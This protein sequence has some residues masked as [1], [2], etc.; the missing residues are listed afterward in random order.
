MK[1]RKIFV[2]FLA[3]CLCLSVAVHAE[4][5]A[6]DSGDNG[7]SSYSDSEPDPEPAPDPEPE[8]DPE[9]VPDPEPEPDPEPAPNPEPDPDPEPVPDPEPE[10]DP[11][12]APD[13]EPEPDPD[14]TPVP[15][16]SDGV[17]DPVPVVSSDLST[18]L[19]G[20]APD[21]LYPA[22]E[23]AMSPYSTYSIDD[24]PASYASGTMADAIINLFGEYQPR[25]QTVTDYHSDGTSVSYEQYVP[26]AAGMDWNW[27]AGAALFTVVLW[28]LFKLLGVFFKNV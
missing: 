25:T 2:L 20:S 21:S 16:P 7:G 4:D 23:S 6:P 10:P 1:L 5:P 8:P 9:P 12:P 14:P 28:S 11:E 15:E 18:G 27:L 24:T 26:G 3:L 22:Y 19:G 13:P 17:P